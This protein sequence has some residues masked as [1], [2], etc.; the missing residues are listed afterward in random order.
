MITSATSDRDQ[1][2]VGA[3]VSMPAERVEV[4]GEDA[5]PQLLYD[6]NISMTF[7]QEGRAARRRVW[8]DAGRGAPGE[9]REVG[10]GVE[11]DLGLAETPLGHLL[12]AV[13]VG[14]R[15]EFRALDGRDVVDER[16]GRL[17][18]QLGLLEQV[19]G[20]AA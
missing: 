6:S 3:I 5:L 9:P 16:L 7:E 15:D 17:A 8:P 2:D 18:L 14:R 11:E 10:D 1:D 19:V 13:H 12:D 20:R 4:C